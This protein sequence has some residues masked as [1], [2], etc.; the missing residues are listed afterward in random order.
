VSNWELNLFEEQWIESAKKLS[1]WEILAEYSRTNNLSELLVES[2]WRVQDWALLKEAFSK[3]SFNVDS[4]R[5]K[6]IQ[7]FLAL[8]ENRIVDVDQLCK[9]AMRVLVSH[10]N[11]LP[12]AP[13]LPHVPL[14]HVSI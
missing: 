11:G 1:Q 2:S 7:S 13:S 14:L 3:F 4:P 8:Y 9:N 6:I 10:W 5:I 12:K